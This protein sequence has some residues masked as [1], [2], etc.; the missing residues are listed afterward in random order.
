MLLLNGSPVTLSV[1]E[2]VRLVITS[3]D[4]DGVATAKEVK[5]FKLFED[6][7]SVYSFQTPPRLAQLQFALQARV[8]SLSQNKKLDLAAS[9]AFG[10]NEI[11]KTEKTENLH[12]A[13]VGGEYLLELRGK[14][15]EAKPDRPVQLSI[16]Q[17]D[18]CEPVNVS[19]Q[20]DPAGQI[21]LG[22]LADIASLTATSPDGTAHTWNLLHDRHSYHRTLHGA[23]GEAI[24]VPYMGP[25]QEPKREAL[26]LL[27]LRGETF[28]QDR[29]DALALDH[30]LLR[31]QG[32]PRGDYDLLLKESGDRLRLRVAEGPSQ[33]GYVL[34][35]ARRLELRGQQPLQIA[36]VDAEP[37]QLRVR[38]RNASKYA[39]VH[40]F[41]TRYA[42]RLLGLRAVEPRRRSRAL[43]LPLGETADV[44]R[45][46]PQ[47]RRRVPLYHR[48]EVCAEIPGQHAGAAQRAAQPVAPAEHR[49][50]AQEAAEGEAYR[51]AAGPCRRRADA[52]GCPAGG[53]RGPGRLRQSRFPVRSRGRGPEPGSGRAGRGRAFRGPSWERT[54]SCTSL[55]SIP[56]RPCTA[57]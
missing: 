7:E 21:A 29:F 9:E 4:H 36:A 37:E 19:L 41:A 11:D 53:R 54:S 14:T 24:E 39:R 32:L 55:R 48:P 22:S 43:R 27:E 34:G 26:S 13:K 31:I 50:R 46:G 45:F 5:D 15:G 18:F 2:D 1:L 49:G 8:Q 35:P 17:R 20:T 12:L 42:A 51:C 57:R 30:G 47:H 40:V 6:R 44:L 10:L 23:A 3:V 52:G 38:L 25:D 16:K 33:R 56:K 28:V